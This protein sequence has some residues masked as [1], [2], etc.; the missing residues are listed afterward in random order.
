MQTNERTQQLIACATALM[1]VA[2]IWLAWKTTQMVGIASRQIGIDERPYLALDGFEIRQIKPDTTSTMGSFKLGLRFRNTG[3]VIAQY[4]VLE[5]NVTVDGGIQEN[6]HY[7]NMRGTVYPE[8]RGV[9]WCA[10]IDNVDVASFP[11]KGIVDYTIDYGSP[12][13]TE[14]YTTHR[15]IEYTIYSATAPVDTINIEEEDN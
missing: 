4:R 11:K 10:A 2:T 14:T 1:A 9:F 13:R 5:I 3:R 7:K 12:G 15:K 6:P 8:D